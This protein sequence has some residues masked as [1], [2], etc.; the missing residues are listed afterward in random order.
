M[1][2][3]HDYLTAHIDA[4]RQYRIN[5][6]TETSLNHNIDF[7]DIS[8]TC[9]TEL[10]ST[11]NRF[12]FHCC[13]SWKQI[14]VHISDC[15]I[16]F[17]FWWKEDFPCLLRCTITDELSIS[18]IACSFLRTIR[19]VTNNVAE[20]ISFHIWSMLIQY[21]WRKVYHLWNTIFYLWETKLYS[22]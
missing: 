2:K 13:F 3:I 18:S 8:F 12:I 1:K 5:S 15:Q 9:C 11:G 19:A 22:E 20:F 6:K 4:R 10:I 21:R 17:S 7:V 14:L 16:I